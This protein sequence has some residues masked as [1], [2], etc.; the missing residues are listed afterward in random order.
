[1]SKPTV[2]GVISS[3]AVARPPAREDASQLHAQDQGHASQGRP[4]PGMLADVESPVPRRIRVPSL[5]ESIPDDSSSP[6]Y[7]T[8][9]APPHAPFASSA[10]RP[11]STAANTSVRRSYPPL[12]LEVVP[13]DQG[14]SFHD[15]QEIDGFVLRQ[16]QPSRAELVDL[17]S[18]E[19]PA[20][21]TSSSSLGSSAIN[22]NSTVKGTNED[23]NDKNKCK[24][25]RK[26]KGKDDDN[27]AK[28]RGKLKTKTRSDSPRP[29]TPRPDTPR[30]DTPRPD[31]PRPPTLLPDTPRP[32]LPDEGPVDPDDLDDFIRLWIRPS[33]PEF[34]RQPDLK[35][36]D[37]EE[38]VKQFVPSSQ[39][40]ASASGTQQDL[41]RGPC[42]PIQR[43]HHSPEEPPAHAS[44]SAEALICDGSTD[45]F[46]YGTAYA[47][48][49][50]RLRYSKQDER[51]LTNFE[52]IVQYNLAVVAGEVAYISSSVHNIENTIRRWEDATNARNNGIFPPPYQQQL[53]PSAIPHNILAPPP[54]GM[55]VEQQLVKKTLIPDNDAI[56]TLE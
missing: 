27:N 1:M 28:G 16:P 45:G 42:P 8:D 15:D 52:R 32:D 19:T 4:S 9:P 49:E 38:T 43:R 54:A 25:D 12:F 55:P 7:I 50:M 3:S 23:N 44:S 48:N 37:I 41:R 14:G 36:K 6:Q 21:T 18:Q 5:T 34:L 31:M 40:L 51:N 13:A 46:Y 22:A 2:N 24:D 30:P 10:R 29:D 56:S 26:G 33:I 17:N 35:G 11:Q 39:K 47:P 20:N 53:P